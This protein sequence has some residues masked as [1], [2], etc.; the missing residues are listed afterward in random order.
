M[1]DKA[2]AIKIIV[3]IMIL[4]AFIAFGVSII[5]EDE[6]QSAY[7]E[8]QDIIAKWTMADPE[9]MS[10]VSNDA[11][12]GIGAFINGVYGV[13]KA[14]YGSVTLMLRIATFSD[15]RIPYLLYL[16]VIL[17][18]NITLVLAVATLFLP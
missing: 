5:Y 17:P 16:F 11:L 2:G 18:S 3:G 14:M 7:L 13:L 8:S 15:P 4:Y 9:S 12:F 6:S 1:G 10:I